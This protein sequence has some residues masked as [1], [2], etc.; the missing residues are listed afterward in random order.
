VPFNAR[1][2]AAV[3]CSG[4][5][6]SYRQIIK[7]GLEKIISKEEEE[8]LLQNGVLHIVFKLSQSSEIVEFTQTKNGLSERGL[9]LKGL[10]VKSII[11][12]QVA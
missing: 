4:C 11:K 6:A 8:N 7:N 3:T 1:H 10:K 5:S 2:D 12:N 9:A